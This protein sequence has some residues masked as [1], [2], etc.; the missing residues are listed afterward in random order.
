MS[1]K[2]ILDR[3]SVNTDSI[4]L[5]MEGGFY[6][7]YER[8]AF[9]LCGSFPGYRV[10]CREL[11][12]EM[13]LSV[14]L[15]EPAVESTIVGQKYVREDET[16]IHAVLASAIS[17][18]E[19]QEWRAGHVMEYMLD[20]LEGRVY[21][22]LHRVMNICNNISDN[23]RDPFGLQIKRLSF[24]ACGLVR[25]LKGA[26]EDVRRLTVERLLHLY[27]NLDFTLKVMRDCRE[28]PS[29]TYIT[30]NEQICSVVKYLSAMRCMV[31]DL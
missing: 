27:D 19:Y 24:Q 5:Y 16:T 9:A 12:Q 14:V 7:A 6:K 11:G 18:D 10:N 13:L 2:E 15:P 28:I 3:E 21:D 25:S 22:I 26:G 17:A 30:L 20:G 31:F 8:S 29:G 23:C 1:Y 4:W